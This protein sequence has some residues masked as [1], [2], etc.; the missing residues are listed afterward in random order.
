MTPHLSHEQ[1]CDLV[2]ASPA[3]IPETGSDA[4]EAAQEHL[5]DCL[6][7]TAELQT[8]CASLSLFRSATLSY[9][10]QEYAR[11]SVNKASIAP[12]P[13]YFSHVLYWAAAAALSVAVILPMSLHRQH[14]PSPQPSVTAAASPQTTESDEALLEG[15][16]KDLSA[17]IPSP[18]R[19][20]A[21]PTAGAATAQSTS[22]QRKN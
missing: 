8:L 17:D 2:L 3:H 7:C 22:D 18:M 20:L 15:I 4:A 16:D 10:R 1:L 11:S 12:S 6:Q 13:R 5:R 19:P 9:A 21:D 14:S